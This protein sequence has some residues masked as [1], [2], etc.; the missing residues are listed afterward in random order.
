[1]PDKKSSYVSLRKQTDPNKEA[2]WPEQQKWLLEQLEKFYRVFG[3]RIKT[4]DTGKWQPEDV[5]DRA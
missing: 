5:E 1:M 2:D 3:P 4:M